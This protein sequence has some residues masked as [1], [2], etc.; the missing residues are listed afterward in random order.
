[1]CGRI[2]FR[3]LAAFGI[4]GGDASAQMFPQPMPPQVGWGQQVGFDP[5][6]RPTRAGPRG[7]A[8]FTA[9]K[10]VQFVSFGSLRRKQARET[11]DEET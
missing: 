8:P 2:A 9:T 5:A 7:P 6:P 1:M 3:L 11:L 10:S 4:L